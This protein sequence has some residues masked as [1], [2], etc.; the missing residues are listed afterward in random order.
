VLTV[1]G[2]LYL[3]PRP[4]QLVGKAYIEI[5]RFPDDE[6]DYDRREEIDG[7]LPE[8]VEHATE[9]VAAE[10]G[11]ELVVLGLKRHE[12]PRLPR[13]VLREAIANAVAHRS[14][15]A[16]GTAV[17]IELRPGRVVITSPGGLPAPV[18]E[19]NIR[20]AQAARNPAALRALRRF[21]LAEDVGRGVDVMQ[22]AMREQLLDQPEFHDQG[23]A[24]TVVLPV[25]GAVAASERAWVREIEQR[26]E[27]EPADR[28]LLVHAARGEELTNAVVRDLLR[29]DRVAA[30]AALQRLRDA[31]F[32]VQRGTR[33]G[34]TYHLDGSLAPPAGLRLSAEQLKDLVLELAR[35][36]PVT[37]AMVRS[38]TGL[39]RAAAL[40]LLDELVEEEKLL[41]TGLKRGTKY[42]LPTVSD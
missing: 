7:T 42:R 13:V 9:W 21:G 20:E 27:I 5:L 10:L 2:A 15:E 1:A 12:L 28:F 31:G 24:V 26:G 8:Q 37:N 38:S 16:R 18:T 17:R 22:D 29:V 32:L 36:A 35:T 40:R 34:A 11:S 14:Y 30:T 39:D 4:A 6:G 3:L 41:R 25:R 33:G 19:Q 23:H